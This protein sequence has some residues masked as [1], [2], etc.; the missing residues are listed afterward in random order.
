MNHEHLQFDDVTIKAGDFCLPGLEFSV[1]EGAYAIMKGAT[2]CG[3]T[4]I[5]ETICGLRPVS[6]GSIRLGGRS[7]E[8]LPPGRRNIGY[9]PQDG[10][11]F[12]TMTALRQIA[13][14]LEL[15]GETRESARSR[16]RELAELIDIVHLLDRR[17]QG[18]SGGERQRVAIAR[19]IAWKPDLLL[20]DEP[21]GALDED[22]RDRVVSA[23]RVVHEHTRVTI[24][25][26]THDPRDVEELATTLYKL[27]EGRVV[28]CP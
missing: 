25:H 16:A 23:L 5:L 2:G 9:V 15:R 19:A 20:M 4:T 11:L 14:P 13:L 21:I 8:T 6:S 27:E 18:F 10:V 22:M 12:P 24:I 1:E 26:V 7:I 17:P 3:K 28:T